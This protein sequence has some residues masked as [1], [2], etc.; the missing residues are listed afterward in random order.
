M[1]EKIDMSLVTNEQYLQNCNRRILREF[2]YEWSK[3]PKT[4]LE[5]EKWLN[6]YI[7]FGKPGE[8]EYVQ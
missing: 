2:L 5:V 7:Q 8:S 6:T 4:E 1:S 3:V